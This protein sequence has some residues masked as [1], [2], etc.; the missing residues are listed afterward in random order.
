MLCILHKSAL[1]RDADLDGAVIITATP[2]WLRTELTAQD[3][4]VNY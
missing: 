1:V 3:S 2:S 4:A